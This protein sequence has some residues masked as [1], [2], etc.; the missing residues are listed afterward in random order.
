MEIIKTDCPFR[1]GE[2]VEP[3]PSY[4][5]YDDW[6]DAELYVV[7]MAWNTMGDVVLT[8]IE[9]T[10]LRDGRTDDF[11]ADNFVAVKP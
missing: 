4:R 5:Y 8:V 7:G 6:K 9:G 3:K 11:P 10:D 1:L 2:R